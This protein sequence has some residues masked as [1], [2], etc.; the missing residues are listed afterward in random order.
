MLGRAIGSNALVVA[1]ASVIGPT[2]ASGVLAIADW[3]WL[4]AIN[5][6][7]G[8]LTIAIASRSLPDSPR[9]PRR[10]NYAG[11]ALHAATFGL[12]VSGL[13]A[14]AHDAA[15]AFAAAQLVTGALLGLLL[16]RHEA[17]RL[18]P[19]IPLDLLRVPLFRLSIAT[20]VCSFTAQMAALVALPFEIQRLGRSPVETGLLMTPWAAA[21]A[22]AAPIAG[23]LADRYAAGILGAIGMMTL[24]SG[25][26][27][28]AIFPPGGSVTSFT[29][30]MAL[31][32]L[33][34]GIFQSPNNRQIL[35][36]APRT[37]SGAAGGMLSTG[38]LLGQTL[39]A[40]WVAILF[41]AYPSRGSNLA[42]A[43][44][45]ALSV[46]AAVVSLWRLRHSRGEVT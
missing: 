15:T 40:A 22:V 27:L 29:L 19:L 20:S 42:L 8:V 12:L 7:I 26:A 14:L 2:L 41:R 31:C 13:Q 5:V 28:L 44:A 24:A 18:A 25:L 10:L 3:R 1:T 16:V 4:F 17:E 45:A 36:A 38:R 30:R 35:L 32:G 43:L 39:G 23:R 21:V 9:A 11:A 37:R 33:G 6:P 46:A 34:F